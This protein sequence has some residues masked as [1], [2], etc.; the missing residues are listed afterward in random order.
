[1]ALVAAKAPGSI[2]GPRQWVK[3]P[4]LPQLWCGWQLWL[5]FNPWPRNFHMP[6]CWVL[7]EK[8]KKKKKKKEEERKKRKPAFG[9][10]QDLRYKKK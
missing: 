1:V 8:E 2:P 9:K 3:D 6:C 4:M 5:R 10:H 7:P